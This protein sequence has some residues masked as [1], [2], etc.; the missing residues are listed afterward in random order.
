MRNVRYSNAFMF[1]YSPREGTKS[2]K[3]NDDVPEEEK[4]RRLNEIIHLQNKISTEENAKEIGKEVEI[5][6]EGTSK[7]RENEW[8]G[9]T[10]NYK[11]VIFDNSNKKTNIG[12][13]INVEITKTTSATLFGQAKY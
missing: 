3:E 8:L 9:K 6:V 13:L 7:K 2:F 10:K 11:L 4:I 1:R 12:D 5:L